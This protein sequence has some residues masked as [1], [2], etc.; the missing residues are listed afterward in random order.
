MFMYISLFFVLLHFIIIWFKKQSKSN[1]LSQIFGIVGVILFTFVVVNL[2][3]KTK[4]KQEFKIIKE[5]ERKR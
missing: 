3:K 2:T 4:E 1:R 5:S